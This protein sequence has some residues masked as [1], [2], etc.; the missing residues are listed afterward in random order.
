MS[1]QIFVEGRITASPAFLRPHG[2]SGDA[3]ALGRHLYLSL[4][5]EVIPRALLDEL[6][7][8]RM[9]LGTAGSGGFLMLL[10]VEFQAASRDFLA[11]AA[12]GLHQLTNGELILDWAITENLGDWSVVR[13][14]LFEE[15]QRHAGTK[16]TAESFLPQPEAPSE[17]ESAYFLSLAETAREATSIAVAGAQ[18]ARLSFGE[19]ERTYALGY[20]GDALPWTP[21][22]DLGQFKRRR[23]GA[24]AVAV[25][26]LEIRLRR[27]ATV[28]EYLRLSHLYKNFFAGELQTL[29][30]RLPDC[31]GKVAILDSSIEGFTI[32]GDVDALLK[33]GQEMH[34]LFHTMADVNLNETA[35]PEGKTLSAALV[36]GDLGTA[37]AEA[38]TA[39]RQAQASSRDAL[40]LFGRVLEWKLLPDAVEIRELCLRMIRNHGANA[41]FVADLSA[42][43]RESSYQSLRRKTGRFERPWRLYRRMSMALG[44]ESESKDFQRTRNRL[45]AEF[46]GKNAGQTRLRP[47]G[48]VGLELTR[49]AIQG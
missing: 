45:L 12:A 18:P 19:G 26:A 16:A 5:G 40:F 10:P 17:Q 3:E 35:G 31:T 46:I 34:R 11:R 21:H 27:A 38:A 24:L 15:M 47:A 25:D 23:G 41:Q 22:L 13:K 8:S 1:I 14:R 29:L 48:R 28:E 32:Y 43:F 33:V 20:A 30:L 36:A 44:S 9:L 37:A 7:L 4:A 2:N 42:F 49:I 6:G 39:L